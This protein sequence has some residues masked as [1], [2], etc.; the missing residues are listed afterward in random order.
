MAAWVREE[1]E[2]SENRQRKRQ[3]EE[4]E[5]VDDEVAPGVTVGSLMT[6]CRV[7]LVGPT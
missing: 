5:K 4:V 3:T 7:A 1:E 2:A 6:R